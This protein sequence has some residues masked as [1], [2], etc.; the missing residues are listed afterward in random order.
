M[1]T[2]RTY[3]LILFSVCG[4]GSLLLSCGNWE[5]PTKKTQRECVKPS[6]TLN[7]PTQQRKVD[8][9]ISNSGGTIDKVNWDFGNGSTSATTGMT[10]SYTYPANGTYTVKATLTNT[11]GLETTIQQTVTVSDAVKPTVTLQAITTVSTTSALAGMTITSNGNATITQYGICYSATNQT[12]DKENDTVVQGALPAPT[13]TAVPMSLTGLQSNVIYYAR[14]FATNAAG[15]VYS[16]VQTFQTGQ[17]P[18]VVTNGTASVGVTTA[19]INLVVQHLGNPAAIEYGIYYSST[20]NIPDVNSPSVKI[21]SP[22]AGANVVVNLNDLTSNKTYYYRSFARLASGEIIYGPI[23]SFTTQIDPVAQDLI[24]SV[25]FTDQSLLDV[26]G[27]NN[28]VQLVDNPTFTTDHKGRPN[29]AIFLD[30]VN[31][32]FYMP[33]NSNNSLNPEALSVSIWFKMS[34]FTHRMQVYNKSRFSDSNFETYSALL[35]LEN[36]LGPNTTVMTNIK[37]NSGCQ[38]GKGWLEF[39]FT[40]R[41]E[42]NT[43]YHLVF[44]Y[45]GRTVRMYLN[46]VPLYTNTDLPLDKMDKCPGAELKFGAAIQGLNWYFHGAMDDIRIY[47]RALTASEVD[48]LYKQ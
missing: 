12:P 15:T 46:N 27:Y 31:D 28:H 48:A 42:V 43:W 18:V 32:Y 33:E 40:S 17:N 2:S 11:C 8:F 14:S 5:V 20:T 1:Q 3:L 22:T 6:G 47:K 41:I 25:S 13:G 9:S 19:S 7:A 10:V 24:A 34:S 26:S 4:L 16:A 45:S 39:P 29:S 21:V 30:G 37:Q 36:D 23:M 44:T 35:K 38:P